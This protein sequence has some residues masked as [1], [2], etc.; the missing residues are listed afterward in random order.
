[1]A[2]HERSSL[3]CARWAEAISGDETKAAYWRTIFEEHTEL[4]RKSPDNPDHYALIWR[5]AL[6]WRYYRREQKMLTEAEFEALT[7]DQREW[8]SRPPVPEGQM[9]TLFDIAVT[10]HGRQ[11]EQNR[12]W[13][14]SAMSLAGVVLGVVVGVFVSK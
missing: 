12:W 6:P 13:V 1:M 9:K 3:D 11:Q 7:G 5:R 2:T 4:F 10:L 8:V 14:P